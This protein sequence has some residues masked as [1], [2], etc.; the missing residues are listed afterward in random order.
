M[1]D[2]IVTAAQWCRAQGVKR[3]DLL[4]VMVQDWEWR[5]EVVRVT[6]VGRCWVVGSHVCLVHPRGR[7]YGGTPEV[8][9][10]ADYE[11]AWNYA[12]LFRPSEA[13][14]D[15]VVSWMERGG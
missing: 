13:V 9:G 3:G 4:G 1:A 2:V 10:G 12:G 7:R 5:Y 8:E 15:A 6:H 11:T 14:H